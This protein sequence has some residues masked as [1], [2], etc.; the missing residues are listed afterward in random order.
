VVAWSDTARL[1]RRA[2]EFIQFSERMSAWTPGQ[3][4]RPPAP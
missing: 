3:I 4:H 1:S 2:E